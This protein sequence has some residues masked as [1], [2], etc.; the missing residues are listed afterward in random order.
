MLTYRSLPPRRSHLRRRFILG[1]LEQSNKGLC[2]AATEIAI[3][4]LLCE[5][6]KPFMGERFVDIG[7]LG[8]T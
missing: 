1:V 4:L 3:E 8:V 7:E 6:D 2:I 5:F